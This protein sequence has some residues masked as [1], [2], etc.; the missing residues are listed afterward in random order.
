MTT[1]THFLTRMINMLTNALERSAQHRTREYLLGLSD[2]HL[3]DMGFS[4]ELL[5]QGPKAWP[6]R[7]PEEALVSI[8][9]HSLIQEGSTV[10]GVQSASLDR[11]H[12]GNEKAIQ[13]DCP[14][15][16]AKLAA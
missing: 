11:I 1:N 15:T 9:V 14:D 8:R 10:S 12:G 3:D 7:K 16:D 2:R 5:K 6:W 13:M 4:R